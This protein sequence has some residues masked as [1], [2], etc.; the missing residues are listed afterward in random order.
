MRYNYKANIPNQ[1]FF[2][3]LLRE[4]IIFSLFILREVNLRI[5]YIFLLYIY[6]NI[7]NNV[8]YYCRNENGKNVFDI[9][10]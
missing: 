6:T 3:Q 1:P 7:S 10:Q 9:K 4:I 8:Y 5:K 2:D